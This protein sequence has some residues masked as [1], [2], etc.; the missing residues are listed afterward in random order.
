MMPDIATAI[1][2]RVQMLLKA[3]SVLDE[4]RSNL[5]AHQQELNR[6]LDSLPSQRLE[7]REKTEL[8]KQA[9]IGA[10]FLA[11]QTPVGRLHRR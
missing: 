3:Q 8:E 6:L 11:G 7:Q 10:T 5:N 1:A 4:A 2:E 9:E